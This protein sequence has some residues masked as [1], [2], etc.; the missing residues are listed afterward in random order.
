EDDEAAVAGDPVA[1]ESEALDLEV[2]LIAAP[3][4]GGGGAGIEEGLLAHRALS[5]QPLG[6]RPRHLRAAGGE[7]PDR[8]RPRVPPPLLRAE[9]RLRG[10]G[11]LRAARRALRPRGGGGAARAGRG[12]RGGGSAACFL[13]S[14]AGGG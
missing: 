2:E 5:W 6:V 9:A 8:A 14:G 4:A 1:A 3:P 10:G 11:R 13:P 12:E 7:L